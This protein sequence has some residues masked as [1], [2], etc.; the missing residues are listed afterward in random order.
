[1]NE[2][3]EKRMVADTGYEVLHTIPLG[4]REI[5]AAVDMTA[6]DGNYYLI[7]DYTENG[8]IGE[9]SQCQVSGDYLEIMQEFTARLDSQ[10]EMIRGR[11][12]KEDFQLEVIDAE[13]CHP[14][15]YGQCIDGKVVAIKAEAL[16]PEYRRGDIQLVWVDGGNGEKASPRG[17]AVFCCHL[18]NGEHTRFERRDVLGEIK[19]LPAWAKE[20]L[21]MVQTEIESR[22]N[23][24]PIGAKPEVVAGYTITKRIQVRKKLFV[25]GENP[26]AIQQYVT[27]QHHEGRT[28][29]DWGHYFSD[30]K[31]ALADL[32][33]RADAE[34][35]DTSPSR[36]HKPQHRDEAR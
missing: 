7:A 26:D 28:G 27:W 29:Y 2:N 20:Q 15:D 24:Q 13:A 19:E 1:M 14:H 22:R 10:I 21:T 8:I 30:H 6:D 25:L 33:S 34:R 12:G 35:A 16:R 4:D 31:K 18:N 36:A 3:Q 9:Y 5:L 32:H 11:I 17:S 23:P